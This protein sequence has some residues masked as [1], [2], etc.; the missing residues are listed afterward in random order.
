MGGASASGGSLTLA[1]LVDEYGEALL[2]DFSFYYHLD[3]IAILNESQT[4]PA[5]TLARVFRLPE[6]SMFASQ[7]HNKEHWREYL[8]ATKSYYATAATFDAV[9]TNTR[10]TGNWRKKPPKIDFYPIPQIVVQK[11]DK[12]V[13]ARSLYRLAMSGS[14]AG[15]KR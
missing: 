6:G 5:A 15:R 12:P 14:M 8:D 1:E 4:P 9:N 2:A 7:C 11:K 3:L 13:T 10:A